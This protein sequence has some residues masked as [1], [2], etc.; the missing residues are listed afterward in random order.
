MSEK[1]PQATELAY[2]PPSAPPT[3]HGHTV[4]AWTAMTGVMVGSLVAG[5][6]VVL[7]AVWLFWVGMGIVALTLIAGGVLRNMGYGQS[8]PG[9]AARATTSQ[10]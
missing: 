10:H 2:L 6:G 8:K 9:V 3:N 7:A 1:K 4:A 5:V